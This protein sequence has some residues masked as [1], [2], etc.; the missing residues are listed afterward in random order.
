[1][2]C[3]F[4]GWWSRSR[5]RSRSPSVTSSFLDTIL[6]DVAPNDPLTFTVLP[7][8]LGLVALVASWLPARRATLVDP[9]DALSTE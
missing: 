5:R 4:R 6:Y 7:L 8:G 9:R 1:M 2:G 3:G